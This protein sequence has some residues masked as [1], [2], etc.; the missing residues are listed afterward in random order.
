MQTEIR[1]VEIRADDEH[2]KGV[3]SGVAVSYSDITTIPEIGLERFMPGA[4]GPVDDLDVILNR[5][6]VRNAPLARTGGGGLVLTDGPDELR[7][8]ATMP[9]TEAARDTLLLVRSRVLRGASIEFKATRERMVSGVRTIQAA[10][11]TGIAICDRPAY[12]QSAVEA[13]GENLVRVLEGALPAMDEP[14][15][16]ARIAELAAAAEID[17]GTVE[18]ILRGEI[19]LPPRQRLEGFASV[20]DGVSLDQLIEAVVADGA[21]PEIYR[22]TSQRRRVWL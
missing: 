17:A 16:P 18:G 15:R 8:E 21:N 1:F 5:Q 3:L 19:D 14:E 4:F 6:H 9:E 12:P 13:R 20:L 2:E 22:A 7:F 10:R 11:L